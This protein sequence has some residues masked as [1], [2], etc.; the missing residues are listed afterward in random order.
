MTSHTTIVARSLSIPAII[1]VDTRLLEELR[2]GEEVI[3]D[4]IRGEVIVA[5]EWE[6]LERYRKKISIFKKKKR[7]Y[8]A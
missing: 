4:A 6:V 5:P 7:N 3:L 1:N 8:W 2:N